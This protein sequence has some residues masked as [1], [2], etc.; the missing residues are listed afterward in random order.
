MNARKNARDVQP[1]ASPDPSSPARLPS[2]AKAPVARNRFS[3]LLIAGPVA[4]LA[5]LFALPFLRSGYA[6]LQSGGLAGGTEGATAAAE[7]W[8]EAWLAD[9][10]QASA[11]RR[12]GSAAEIPVSGTLKPEDDDFMSYYELLYKDKERYYGREIEL[13]GIVMRDEGLGGDAFLIGR[14]LIWCCEDDADY[15]GY[16]A[17]GAGPPPEDGAAVALRG[18]LERRPY[19]DAERGKTFDV[20]AIRI[21]SMA[22]SQDFSPLV[23]PVS[24]ALFGY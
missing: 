14:S 1:A 15:V 13:A 17:F 20:P 10:P 22:P 3:F 11:E 5:L 2:T 6:R 23:Y 24:T 8:S 16:V 19:T 4:L 21:R 18:V 9:N 7:P 12:Q